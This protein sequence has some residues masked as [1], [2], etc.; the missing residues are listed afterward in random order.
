MASKRPATLDEMGALHGVG[1][2][3]L[4][5]FGTAFLKAIRDN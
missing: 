3:K 1:A 4:E 5:R 2:A